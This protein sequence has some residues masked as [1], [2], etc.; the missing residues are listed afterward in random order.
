MSSCVCRFVTL[1][2]KWAT[3][4]KHHEPKSDQEASRLP[5]PVVVVYVLIFLSASRCLL[6]NLDIKVTIVLN[7]IEKAF[8]E[9]VVLFNKLFDSWSFHE[10]HGLATTCW[11]SA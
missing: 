4:Y 7:D 2:E 1:C 8:N 6:T 10:F 5:G 3:G 11:H 9:E